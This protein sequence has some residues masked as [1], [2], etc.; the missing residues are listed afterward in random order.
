MSSSGIQHPKIAS[1]IRK[2]SYCCTC[3]GTGCSTDTF[4]IKTNSLAGFPINNN[5]E[6]NKKLVEL[7][8]YS[9]AKDDA[10]QTVEMLLPSAIKHGQNYNPLRYSNHNHHRPDRM[11]KLGTDKREEK[12]TTITPKHLYGGNHLSY[13]A[14]FIP[15]SFIVLIILANFSGKPSWF[16]SLSSFPFL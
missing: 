5:K 12:E 6:I 16:V 2:D 14:M 11:M 4:M 9:S 13:L 7:S 10:S 1:P 15:L 3:T 8:S